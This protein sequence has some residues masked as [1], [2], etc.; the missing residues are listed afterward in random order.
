MN[1]GQEVT[2]SGGGSS[3]GSIGQPNRLQSIIGEKDLTDKEVLNYIK[4]RRV[5]FSLMFIATYQ[6]VNVKT[7]SSSNHDTIDYAV[8][9]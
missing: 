4:V 2:Q 3:A 8:I 9:Q 1:Q 5:I 7:R 6:A